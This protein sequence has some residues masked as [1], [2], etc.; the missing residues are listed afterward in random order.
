[1]TATATATTYKI[2]IA[3][4]SA[5]F[6]VAHLGISKVK[7]EF[8]DVQGH[9][10]Y[11]PANPSASKVEAVIGVASI[12]TREEK[13]DAHLKSADFFDVENFPTM[14]FVS[15]KVEPAGEDELKITGD[16][17]IRGVSK[18]VVLVVEGPTGEIKD[19]WG[20]FRRAAS[21]R[22]SISRKD[23]GMTWNSLLET[24]GLLVGD[25][26]DIFIE[27]EMMVQSESGA[28]Q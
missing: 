3:H 28:A 26:V 8:A 14:T 15:T 27:I 7:G 12:S 5:T 17:T 11:D 20:V 6:A 10:V 24:G 22:T 25:K 9:V 19:P 23:Y 18:S 2:D 4:S 1:M 16:L 13:R 21:A